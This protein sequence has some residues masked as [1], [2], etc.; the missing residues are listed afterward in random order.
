MVYKTV[1]LT[2]AKNAKKCF[3]FVIH[4]FSLLY[5]RPAIVLL[6]PDFAAII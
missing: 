2:G 5:P 1:T 6:P 3:Y 4:R